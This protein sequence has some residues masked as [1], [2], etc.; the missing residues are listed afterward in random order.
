[1]EGMI[2]LP[3]RLIGDALWLACSAW[4]RGARAIGLGGLAAVAGVLVLACLLA[5][6]RWVAVERA[7]LIPLQ[8]AVQRAQW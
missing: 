5:A 7:R 4:L 1:M 2:S 8:Q 3:R 6:A